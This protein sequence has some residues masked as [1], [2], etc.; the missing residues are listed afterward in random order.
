MNGDK[1]C[2][3]LKL[4]VRLLGVGLSVWVITEESILVW[5]CCEGKGVEFGGV[6]VFTGTFGVFESTCGVFVLWI[7]VGEI[8]GSFK[9]VRL[10]DLVVMFSA[11]RSGFV[12]EWIDGGVVMRLSSF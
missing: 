11:V 7:C 6:D 9:S 8:R 3:V 2:V 1:P 5:V 10:S 4:V 12:E